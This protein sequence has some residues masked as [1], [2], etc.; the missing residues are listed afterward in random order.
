[1]LLYAALG[2]LYSILH[3]YVFVHIEVHLG[4][5]RRWYV[6]GCFVASSLWLLGLLAALMSISSFYSGLST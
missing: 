3:V 6:S 5:T 4:V 1:M 2:K